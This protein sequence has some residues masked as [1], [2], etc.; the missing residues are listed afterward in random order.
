MVNAAFRSDQL[1]TQAAPSR[2]PDETEAEDEELVIDPSEDEVTPP[3]E[4][5][6]DRPTPT[7]PSRATQ[8]R[9]PAPRTEDSTSAFF[10][11]NLF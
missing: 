5:P 10:K 3:V 11:S 1:P 6:P 7:A 9:R 4:S 2:E 8:D